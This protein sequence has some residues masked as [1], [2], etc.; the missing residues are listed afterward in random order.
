MTI[1]KTDRRTLYTIQVIKKAFLNLINNHNYSQLSVAQICR[2]AGTTRSTFYLHFNNL[3]ALLNSVLDDALMISDH[4]NSNLTLASNITVDFLKKNE[5][6]LP[7]C[8][9]IADPPQYRSL[10]M[11]PDLSEYIIGRIANYEGGRMVPQIMKRTGL[12][13]KDAK[14][15]FLYFLHGSFAINK[16]HH[17]TKDD[18]WYHEVKML[19][20]FINAGYKSF[21][22]NK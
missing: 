8:Q 17:F 19:N 18:E 11:D 15:L 22:H 14:T 16:R 1:R 3:S 4:P 5:S 7:T 2:K 12:G 13:N 20:Q 10:L 21:T 9:R 6:L